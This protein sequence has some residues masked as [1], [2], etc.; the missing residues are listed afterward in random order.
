[1]DQVT[2]AGLMGR[3]LE[4]LALAELM[5]ERAQELQS[6]QDPTSGACASKLLSW[7]ERA[8][9]RAARYESMAAFVGDSLATSAAQ[10]Q[11]PEG[12]GAS[13]PSPGVS[14]EQFARQALAQ[15]KESQD[16]MRRQAVALEG[17]ASVLLSG[18]VFVRSG[19]AR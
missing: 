19:E 15:V 10:P 6:I 12:E 4:A 1:M 11:Q 18:C 3:A 7:C 5:Q 13:A 16:L 9:A 14:A 2:R 8:R 17:I